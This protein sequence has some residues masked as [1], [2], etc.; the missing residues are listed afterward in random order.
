MPYQ[1]CSLFAFWNRGTSK[2]IF[3]MA[4]M[5]AILLLELNHFN[6]FGRESP[7]QHQLFFLQVAP[8]LSSKIRVSSPFGSGD[9]VQNRFL[10]WRTSWI[11]DLTNICFF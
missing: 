10:R 8:I 6:V 2:Y 9:E 3:K 4:A 5:V 7:R 1:V 11:F